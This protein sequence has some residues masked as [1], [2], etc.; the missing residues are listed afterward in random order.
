MQKIQN[1]FYAIILTVM[2]L[3]VS[4]VLANTI[5][6]NTTE[7]GLADKCSLRQAVSA[8]NLRQN[9][10]G[11]AAGGQQSIIRLPAG[12]FMLAPRPME[13]NSDI[14]IIGNGAT[15]SII[16]ANNNTNIFVVQ[17]NANL[18]LW[19]VQLTK[20][21]TTRFGAAISNLGGRVSLYHSAIVANFAAG[22]MAAG[23]GIFN[24]AGVLNLNHTELQANSV[25]Y[26]Y[27]GG[28]IFN[29]MGE[30]NI[31]SSNFHTNNANGFGGGAIYNS[32]GIINILN[33]SFIANRASFGG[34]LFNW[35][36]IINLANTTFSANHA[37]FG[38]AIDSYD[39]EIY[40]NHA[41]IVNNTASYSAGIDNDGLLFLHNSIVLANQASIANDDCNNGS[42]SYIYN[43]GYN[44]FVADTT[45]PI[46]DKD[47]LLTTDLSD[48]LVMELDDYYS[49]ALVAD[50]IAVA[51]PG[52]ACRYVSHPYAPNPLFSNLDVVRL[53]QRGAM[54]VS[55]DIGAYAIAAAPNNE[56]KPTT[57]T[58]NL[59]LQ[60]I[61]EA[62][63][64]SHPTAMNC[65]AN[66]ICYADF[67][68]GTRIFLTAKPASEHNLVAWEGDCAENLRLTRS[69]AENQPVV[70]Q[71]ISLDLDGNK[72]CKLI[73]K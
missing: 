27:A 38:G 40:L 29:Y 64:S 55:C 46:G 21:K 66:Q 44:I 32:D 11:C 56:V 58:Y 35:G 18:T 48:L 12:E 50:S 24:Y 30:V 31:N 17:E 7:D 2:G 33:S 43:S 34:G 63:V 45:C 23:A 52:A 53:D 68:S 42:N 20:G 72:Q 8:A 36:G 25:E 71:T 57:H 4:N 22:S 26:G 6:V 49:H 14:I 73:V 15:K 54:R 62:E 41:T 19:H 5:Y 59:R 1:W 69:L 37:I 3:A 70:N 9:V 60:I 13:I 39:G 51:V 47:R 67:Y 61:G 65:R 16:N 10:A 28:G